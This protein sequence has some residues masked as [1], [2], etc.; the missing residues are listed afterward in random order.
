[1]QIRKLDP[2]TYDVFG[3]TGFDSWTR[4]RRFH[5]GFKQI[6]GVFLPRST[7][8]SVIETI[9]FNPEGSIDNIQEKMK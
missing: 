1:M 2:H 8:Q 7:L 6:A 5:W 4:L 9:Q 3:G